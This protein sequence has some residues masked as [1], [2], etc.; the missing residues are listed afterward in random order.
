MR[1]KILAGVLAVTLMSSAAFAKTETVVTKEVGVSGTGSTVTTMTRYYYNDVDANNNGIL[2]SQEF[3]RFVYSR[4]DVNG[5]GFIS[6]DEWQA[7][8]VRW[9]PQNYSEYKTYS[10][11]DTD[12]NGRLDADEFGTVVTTTKLYDTWDVDNNQSLSGDEFAQSVF[13]I[14]DANGDG[15]ISR[16]E[17][18]QAQ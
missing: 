12:H 16:E 15:V 1:I 13:G 10:H 4:W 3:P 5:D 7:N 11:W 9:Y 18:K 8:T 2:D 14:Y 6:S 17:W